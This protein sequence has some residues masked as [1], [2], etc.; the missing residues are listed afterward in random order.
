MGK[1]TRVA[2]ADHLGGEVI[3][4]SESQEHQLFSH[5][6]S[7]LRFLIHVGGKMFKQLFYVLIFS[8][9]TEADSMITFN[10][11]TSGTPPPVLGNFPVTGL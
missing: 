6:E 7:A 8:K 10:N 2:R 5:S 3:W 9:T 4:V 11:R 1:T